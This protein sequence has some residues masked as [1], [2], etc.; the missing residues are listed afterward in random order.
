MLEKDLEQKVIDKI[1]ST[2]EANVIEGVQVVG[3]WQVVD[4]D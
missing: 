3:A 2:F 4:A 1:Q